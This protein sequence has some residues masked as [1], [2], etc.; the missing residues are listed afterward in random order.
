MEKIRNIPNHK[1]CTGKRVSISQIPRA[2]YNMQSGQQNLICAGNRSQSAIVGQC[3]CVKFFVTNSGKTQDTTWTSTQE[4]VQTPF[5][6][7][8]SEKWLLSEESTFCFLSCEKQCVTLPSWTKTHFA[9]HTIWL[10]LKLFCPMSNNLQNEFCDVFNWT[11]KP[12]LN[13][14]ALRN[15]LLSAIWN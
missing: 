2:L 3:D 6:E 10:I 15:R 9:V 5:L 11:L 13:C 7:D 8:T 12:K 4:F 1:R 14:S